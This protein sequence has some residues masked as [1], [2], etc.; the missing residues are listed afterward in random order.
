MSLKPNPIPPVP[1][2]TARAAFPGGNVLV[3]LRDT[4][5]TVYTDEQIADLF[6]THG[7]PAQAQWRLALVIVIATT[8]NVVNS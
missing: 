2:E 1:E 4:V 3:Q 7:Q 5:G 8:I 6:P